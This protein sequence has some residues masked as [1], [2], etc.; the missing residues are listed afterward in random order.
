MFLKSSNKNTTVK[1]TNGMKPTKSVPSIIGAGVKIIG[2]ITSNGE[3]QLDGVVEGD[4]KAAKLII[5]EQGSVKG[6]II[7]ESIIVMG[8][9]SGQLRAHSIRLEKSAKVKGELFHETI[10]IETGAHIEG[11]MTHKENPLQDKKTKNV[12]SITSK[13]TGE[14]SA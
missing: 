1:E 4:I 6:V 7:A 14:K 11:T 9:V 13:A 3:I 8:T 2:D 12:S 5:G 10:S